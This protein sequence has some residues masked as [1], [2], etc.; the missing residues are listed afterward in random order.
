M[1]LYD[2]RESQA[3]AAQDVPFYALIMAAMR[4]ADTDNLVRLRNAFPDVHD[5]LTNRYNAAGGLLQS[6]REQ[7]GTDE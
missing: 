3:L 6:E 7:K 5:E 2:Y 1:S 4:R